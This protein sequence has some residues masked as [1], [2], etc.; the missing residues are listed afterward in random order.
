MGSSSERLPGTSLQKGALDTTDGHMGVNQA[1]EKLD[2]QCEKMKVR[3]LRCSHYAA[4]AL[5][6][7]ASHHNPLAPKSSEHFS[8]HI[9]DVSAALKLLATPLVI[10]SPLLSIVLLCPDNPRSFPLASFRNTDGLPSN[11]P[12]L[13][14]SFRLYFPWVVSSVTTLQLSFVLNNSMYIFVFS[15]NACPEL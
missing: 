10:L 4:N 11:I 13:F 8:V 1:S 12:G 9:F 7:G 3:T 15:P 14:S 5:L 6:L 2:E